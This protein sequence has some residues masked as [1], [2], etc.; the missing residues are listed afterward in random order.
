GYQIVFALGFLSA[1][2]STLHLGL[3]R[4]PQ[5]VGEISPGQKSLSPQRQ[6]EAQS[7]GVFKQ[8]TARVSRSLHFEI[9][10]GPFRTVLW[11]MFAFHLAQFLPLPLF[12]IFAVRVLAVEDQIISIANAIFFLAMLVGS[13]QTPRLVAKIGN[14]KTTG[15][16]LMFLAGYP[17]VLSLSYDPAPYLAAHLL[18]GT[19]WGFA[20]SA[21]FNFVL[22]RAEPQTRST[23][24]AWFNLF[25]NAGILLGSLMGPLIGDLIGI[26]LA[27][28]I[29]ALIRFLTGFNILRWK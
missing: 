28:V 19:G 27:F 16:G 29:F 26:R 15:L 20:S 7:Q 23:H 9:I 10:I 25:A 11:M 1:A 24:L 3:V 18:G 6:D 22:E 2:L 4:I 5:Q 13:S 14:Q 12:P 17:L 8:V 21:M